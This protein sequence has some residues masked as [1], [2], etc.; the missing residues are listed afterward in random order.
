[1]SN[2]KDVQILGCWSVK[3]RSFK[4]SK[5][6]ATMVVCPREGHPNSKFWIYEQDGRMA[7]FVCP[8]GCPEDE[9]NK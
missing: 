1:M 4:C 2:A 9:V 6:G 8:N 3:N 7:L 5:C